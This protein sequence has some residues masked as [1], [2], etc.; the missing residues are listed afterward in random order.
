MFCN[1][2]FTSFI[3]NIT[4]DGRHFTT[5]V[6]EPGVPASLMTVTEKMGE[7]GPLLRPYPD[8]S[9]YSQNYSDCSKIINVYRVAVSIKEAQS[10]V[11]DT[12]RVHTF[13]VE[14]KGFCVCDYNCE[15]K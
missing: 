5:A 8:W 15:V 7:G 13:W 1:T 11:L 10:I 9:W 4:V 12:K 2:Y 3:K 6:R 14:I